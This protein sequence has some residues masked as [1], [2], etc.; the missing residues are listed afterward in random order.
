MPL[1]CHSTH[2][3]GFAHNDSIEETDIGLSDTRKE[4]VFAKISLFA[5]E[6]EQ[7]P[8]NLCR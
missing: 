2:P 5:P 1:V 8:V 3:L 6:L 4:D 7:T